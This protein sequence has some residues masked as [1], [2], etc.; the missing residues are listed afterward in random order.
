MDPTLRLSLLTSAL[1]STKMQVFPEEV[2]QFL[3]VLSLRCGGVC[4]PIPGGGLQG[5]MEEEGET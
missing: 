2:K 1:V 5:E 3:Q 4:E